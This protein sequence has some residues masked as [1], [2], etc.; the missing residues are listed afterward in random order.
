MS[1]SQNLFS[2]LA[3]I[4]LEDRDETPSPTNPESQDDEFVHK[5][6]DGE[7]YYK[8]EL[9]PFDIAEFEGKYGNRPI[10]TRKLLHH[11]AKQKDLAVSALHGDKSLT[12]WHK[13]MPQEPGAPERFVVAEV[14]ENDHYDD[15]RVIVH[16]L[17]RVEMHPGFQQLRR[18][19]QSVG[20]LRDYNWDPDTKGQWLPVPFALEV[21]GR[22]RSTYHSDTKKMEEW[23]DHLQHTKKLWK[24]SKACKEVGDAVLESPI[25]VQRIVC[26]GLGTLSFEEKDFNRVLQHLM[27]IQLAEL[28]D[29]NNQKKDLSL[30]PVEVFLQDPAYKERDRQ[31]LQGLRNNVKFVEDPQGVLAIDQDT[32]VIG[33]FVPTEFPLMQIIADSFEEGQGPAAFLIDNIQRRCKEPEMYKI[34]D[35]LSPRAVRMGR[36]YTK[37]PGTFGNEALGKELQEALVGHPRYWMESMGLWTRKKDAQG[38]AGKTAP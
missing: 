37:Y 2:K 1:S 5:D 28:L 27:V 24:N 6:S 26:F 3:D 17:S 12:L 29:E 38:P 31:L 23:R 7:D 21:V 30:P 33:A 34:N 35:R 19:S 25:P 32:F 16:Y 4:S 22:D 13:P 20:L 9:D 36:N 14:R 10:F 18:T 15:D 11:I 8:W